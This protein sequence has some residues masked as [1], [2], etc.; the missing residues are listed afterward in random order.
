VQ[1]HARKEVR[2]DT[3]GKLLECQS[4]NHITVR[5]SIPSTAGLSIEAAFFHGASSAVKFFGQ[6]SWRQGPPAVNGGTQP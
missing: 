3:P 1:H 6:T 2:Y 4:S 5:L